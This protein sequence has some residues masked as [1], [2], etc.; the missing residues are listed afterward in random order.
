MSVEYYTEKGLQKLNDE[1]KELTTVQRPAITK[2]IADARDKG[3][4]L[5]RY[6]TTTKKCH[7]LKGSRIRV[8]RR[9]YLKIRT[10]KDRELSSFKCGSDFFS[11]QFKFLWCE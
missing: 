2:E 7:P 1:L 8:G 10:E 3:D 11:C 4:L 6:V 5:R 9:F